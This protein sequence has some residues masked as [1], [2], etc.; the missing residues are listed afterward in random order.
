MLELPSD[1]REERAAAATTAWE[2]PRIRVE[3]GPVETGDQS[4][5]EL[6]YHSGEY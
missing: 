5:E 1:I 6:G 3:N 2:L 4:W